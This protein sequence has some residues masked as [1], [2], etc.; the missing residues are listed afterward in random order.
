MTGR[1]D[2]CGDSDRSGSGCRDAFAPCRMLRAIATRHP[3]CRCD[4]K[5]VVVKQE[6]GKARRDGRADGDEHWC[7][8]GAASGRCAARAGGEGEL[9]VGSEVIEQTRSQS[10]FLTFAP[11]CRM[12]ENLD[13]RFRQGM[14]SARMRKNRLPVWFVYIPGVAGDQWTRLV[15]DS[16]TMLAPLPSGTITDLSGGKESG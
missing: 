14:R 13:C 8:S 15:L 7:R 3:S 4:S 12:P 9:L 6:G 2:G 11:L 16:K 1:D 5:P 10:E